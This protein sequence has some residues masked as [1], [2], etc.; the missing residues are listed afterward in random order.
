MD[1]TVI[2]I[3]SD[4]ING[5]EEALG[6][7][8]NGFAAAFDIKQAGGIASII[9]QGTG[10]RW[11]GLITKVDHPAHELFKALKEDIAGVSSACADVFGATEDAV[12]NEFELINEAPIPG[13]SGVPSVAKLL[14]TGTNILTF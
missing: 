11:A 2:I 3:F 5:G 7:L 14:K 10:T 13:T 6:R 9:F 1:K 4:P 12:T 8:F